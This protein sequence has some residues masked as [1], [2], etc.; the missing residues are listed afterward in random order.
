VVLE[1]WL[2][3]HISPSTCAAEIGSGGGRVAVRVA[4]RVAELT[5]FDVSEEM[6]GVARKHLAAGGHENVNFRQISGGD[7]YPPEYAGS[8]D[9]VYSFDVFV[10]MDL[11]Q[12]WLTLR[13]IRT[14]LVPGGLCFVS[15]ANLLAPNGWRRFARQKRYSVGGFYFVSP[16]IARCLLHRAGLE[17]C[18]ASVPCTGNTYLCRDLLVLARRPVATTGPE[19]APSTEP[20][21]E[22]AAETGGVPS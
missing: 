19:N 22:G 11:H 2:F 10:H 20:G 12:M 9:V 8:F 14:L 3:P 21:C 4:Q 15:F 17:L 13:S 6:L 1:D 7:G 18:R 5:C 16:D